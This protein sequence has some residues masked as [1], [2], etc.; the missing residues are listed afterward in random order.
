M[1]TQA[2]KT[3]DDKT[4]SVTNTIS[5]K[6]SDGNVAFQQTDNNP[7]VQ[8]LKAYQKMADNFTGE[9]AQRQ[10]NLEEEPL[11]GKF[12]TAQRVEE[13]EPLQ[14]KFETAQRVEEEEPLQGKFETVQRVEEEEPLQG[15]FETAQ[16]VEEEEPL[17]GKFETAQLKQSGDSTTQLKEQTAPKTNNTG[18]PD[19]LKSGIENISGFAMDDVKVHYNSDKPAQLQAH[20]YAQG[21][22]IH[23]GSG[24]EKHLPHE[25]WHVVQQK[26]GRVQP[27][28][29]LKGKVNVNDDAGLETEADVMGAKASAQGKDLKPQSTA[30][31]RFNS[32]LTP[33][34]S[35]AQR[36]P[37]STSPVQ[38]NDEEQTK[39]AKG[40]E[41]EQLNI[42]SNL[43]PAVADETAEEKLP[44]DGSNLAPAVA[45]E[46][47]VGRGRAEAVVDQ[48]RERAEAV[49]DQTRERA[50]AIDETTEQKFQRENASIIRMISKASTILGEPN[51]WPE[52]A[53]SDTIGKTAKGTGV[54][55]TIIN[56]AGTA[57][58]KKRG[59]NNK[60][61]LAKAAGDIVSGVGSSI[62]SLVKTVLTL[63]NLC[64]TADG[65]ETN[66]VG[67]GKTA[68]EIM[69]ALKSGCEAAMSIQKY[70]DGSVPP[71]IKSLIPGLGIAIAACKT[72]E[73]TYALYNAYSAE[74]E[75]KKVSEGFREDLKMVLT[76]DLETSAKTL[77]ADEERGKTFNKLTYRR[78]QPG[79]FES[80][81][82]IMDLEIQTDPQ[83]QPDSDK[84]TDQEKKTDLE[85]Q[86]TLNA[87][88][89][90][91]IARFKEKHKLPPD[92]NLN[93]LF[94]AIK[95]YELGSKM[96]EINQKRKVQGARN[97]FTNLLSIA[98][99]IAA[100]FPA[101]GGITTGVLLGTSSAIEAA[102]A[103]G[104]FIQGVAR[105]RGIFGGDPNRGDPQKHKEY[106]NHTRTIYE[107]MASIDPANEAK[108]PQVVKSEQL[109]KSTG[110][111]ISAVYATEYDDATSR[112]KQ[113]RLIIEAMKAGR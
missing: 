55:A 106:V 73:N 44:I 1:H 32:S 20:A 99:Q 84:K 8:Q 52:K 67:G 104:K 17:Q 37:N 15:K 26:Q 9:I 46:S 78:L 29:Q 98:G 105:N 43:A 97:V 57:T 12:E 2:D 89:V 45:D 14:G 62:G 76:S 7:Q 77:F 72:I 50:K 85:K 28:M 63:K 39:S 86:K 80:I 65:V 82:S 21:T 56:A 5:R 69:A 40:A 53:E 24:Q 41:E 49:V 90:E 60:P 109:L 75:M 95:Y 111:N 3:Q 79:L 19:N 103:A 107:L 6:Q 33:Y 51:N 83:K 27:T 102:Q 70:I 10:E 71:G 47:V 58:N 101:D 100:F 13:E 91:E 96:Q 38:L 42:G 81:I 4:Q 48:T 16:R 64:T 22:D 36:Q 66:L 110:V 18:L 11:Q 25:A 61:A 87:K 88:K 68:I 113:V 35:L 54:A 59:E 94:S 74:E 112:Q 30:Q 23:L 31:L 93:K 108:E 34:S 92:I